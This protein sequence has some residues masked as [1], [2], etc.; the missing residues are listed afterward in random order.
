[1]LSEFF[2]KNS[3]EM[4][5]KNINSFH[6]E[7]LKILEDYTWPGN[8]RELRNVVEASCIICSSSQIVPEDLP[9][10]LSGQ[11]EPDIKRVAREQ[12]R[13]VYSQRL[14]AQ[15][16]GSLFETLENQ[17]IIELMGQHNGNK[18]KVAQALNITRATLYKRLRRIEDDYS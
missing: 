7:T 6:P 15:E 13:E 10:E 16:G 1:M 12:K 18:T 8:I 9:H 17:K 2:L 4:L 3:S 5:E 11:P 14:L